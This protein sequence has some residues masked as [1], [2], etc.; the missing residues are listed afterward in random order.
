MV[1]EIPVGTG[2]EDLAQNSFFIALL[3]W[4]LTFA[5]VYGIL[6]HYKIPKSPSSR[7]IISIVLA[8]FTIP[9]A[10]PLITIIGSMGV[11][12]V[13]F[14]VAI[15][16]L[17]ILFELTGTGSIEGKVTPKGIEAQKISIVHKYSSVFAISVIIIAIIIFIGA[18]G[19]NLLGITIPSMNYPAIF[20]FAI[21]TIV[22]IWMV[23]GEKK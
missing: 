21:M 20:F 22:I 2:L 9:A 6:Q 8:F 7:A 10:G 15:L 23:M 11:G 3:P 18:G 12:L 13:I 5:I 4:L 16:F 14:F 17:L 19:L 1:Y